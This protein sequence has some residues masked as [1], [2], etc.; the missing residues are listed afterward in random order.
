MY[1]QNDFK[2]LKKTLGLT[3]QEISDL[4]GLNYHSVLNALNSGKKLPNWAKMAL[5]VYSNEKQHNFAKQTLNKNN[6][7]STYWKYLLGIKI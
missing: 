2:E 3:N 7:G 1:T 4:L 5:H 6:H